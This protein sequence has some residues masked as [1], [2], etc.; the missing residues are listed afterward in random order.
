MPS[1]RPSSATACCMAAAR[2]TAPWSRGARWLS[3]TCGDPP[4][5]RCQ[6]RPPW[7]GL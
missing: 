2:A 1:A 5:R 6:G 4:E 3:V 7:P